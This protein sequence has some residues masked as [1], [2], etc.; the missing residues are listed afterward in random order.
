MDEHGATQTSFDEKARIGV[1]HFKNFF[2]APSQD[3]IFEVIRVAQL[4]PRFFEGGR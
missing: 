1:A 4:F 3:S 2:K